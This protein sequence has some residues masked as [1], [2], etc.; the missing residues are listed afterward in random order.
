MSDAYSDKLNEME[1][2]VDAMIPNDVQKRVIFSA[3]N[4]SEATDLPLNN[5]NSVAVKGKVIMFQEADG[6]WG[7]DKGKDFQS[8]V[9][10]NPTWLQMAVVANA[11]I[12]T[13]RDSHHV[14]LE[15]VYAIKGKKIDGV[16]VYTFSMGS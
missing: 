5:L 3:Y 12:E 11:M 8:P 13:V 2:A 1:D 7:N 4:T 15:G 14:F 16:K 6:F 9:L 10:E